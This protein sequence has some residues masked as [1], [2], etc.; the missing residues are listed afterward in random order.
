MLLDEAPLVANSR[1]SELLLRIFLPMFH[2]SL[3]TIN[4]EK[5]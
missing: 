5:L 3:F 1:V 2:S 4:H